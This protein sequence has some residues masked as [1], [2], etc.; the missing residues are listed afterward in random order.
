M[1]LSTATL[2]SITRSIEHSELDEGWSD[3]QEL[4][5]KQGHY[6]IFVTYRVLGEFIREYN[7]HSEV[8]YD[9]Y[10]NMSHID[11]IAAEIISIEAWDEDLEQAVDIDN[12]YEVEYY[13]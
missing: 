7:Y 12:L 3:H 2:K 13:N 4:D 11:F 10:E 9:C 8:L 1:V 6:I 5:V